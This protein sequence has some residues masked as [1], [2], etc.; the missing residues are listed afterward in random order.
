[1]AYF[2]KKGDVWY[3]TIEIPTPTGERKRV[4]RPGG[5]SRQEAKAAYRKAIAEFEFKKKYDEVKLAYR[6]LLDERKA[7][8]LH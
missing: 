6:D 8:L 5:Y 2:R 4:E 3:Y 7:P 1:M